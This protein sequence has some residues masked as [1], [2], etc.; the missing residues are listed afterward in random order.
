MLPFRRLTAVP[1]QIQA[2]RRLNQFQSQFHSSA[3]IMVKVGD[4][5]PN[6]DVL[7]EGAPSNKVNLAKELT[8]KGIIVGVPAAFSTFPLA[9]C[10]CRVALWC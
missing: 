7:N 4:S 9:F 1:P 10:C 8:G 3:A 5:I 2:I 6:L